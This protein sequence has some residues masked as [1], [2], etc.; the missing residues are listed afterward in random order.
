MDR[1]V[2][3]SPGIITPLS[4]GFRMERSISPEELRYYVMYWD[5]VVIPRNNLVYIG[6]PEEEDLIA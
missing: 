4:Q 5:K 1:G 3:A 2:I 6:V